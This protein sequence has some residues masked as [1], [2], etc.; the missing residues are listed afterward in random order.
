LDKGI[1]MG[2]QSILI[3]NRAEIAVRVIKTCRQ[4]GIKSIAIYSEDD[5]NL[6]HVK[7]ADVAYSLGR[8]PASETYLN[9]DKIIE[10]AKKASVDAIHPGYGFLS[11]NATFCEAL[12]KADI[13]FIGPS[14][15][16][17][18]LMG[19]K[20]ESKASMEK[21]GIPLVPGYHGD[22]QDA[23]VLKE[24]AKKIGFPLLIKASAGGGGKGMRIVHA[25]KDFDEALNSAKSEAMK[26]FSDDKV[27]LEKYIESPRHIEVQ[28]VSDAHGNHLHFFERE[29]SIQRR[30]QKIIE[31]TP[32]VA[33]DAQLRQKICETAVNVAKGIDYLGA[34][35]VEFILT[36]NKEFYF[37]EMNTRLQVEHPIT[38]M[39]TGVD[40]VRLQILAANNEKLPYKQSDIT[41]K[42]HSLEVRI[43]SEDPDNEFLPATGMIEKVNL[44]ESTQARVDTGYDDGNEVTINYDP[45]IAKVIVHEKTRQEAISSMNN[46]LNEVVFAGVKTN[47][48]YLKRIL[49]HKAFIS[50]ELDTH[51]VVTYEKDLKPQKM[52]DEE[53]SMILGQLLLSENMNKN[54]SSA[55]GN[56]NDLRIGQ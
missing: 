33:L 53:V 18:T 19:S 17:I 36:P 24:E 54:V 13:T 21:L 31:E 25:E 29:C 40:L 38:E 26:A 55:W 41:Q 14:V 49:K 6:K 42:G 16:A 5:R 27:L 46:V 51:F 3:A 43:Y 4:M 45:M 47:R 52:S 56:I 20:K 8:G 28:I 12:K 11:E 39:V 7:M 10:I 48:D 9:I 35:T 1:K 50:G 32:S 44:N 22:N 34:G 37:L 30:Y 15:E 2:I 23:K